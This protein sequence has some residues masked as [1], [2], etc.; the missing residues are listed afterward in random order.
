MKIIDE[1]GRLFGKIN[2]LDLIIAV[3]LIMLVI[4]VMAKFGKSEASYVTSDKVLEYT[5]K[6]EC[7]RAPT[8]DAIAQNHVGLTDFETGKNVGDIVDTKVSDSV[9]LIKLADGTYAYANH[10]DRYDLLITL[11][12][13]G[14]ET[15][16]N[17]FTTSGKKIVVGD[18]FKIYN[19]YAATTA[20]VESVKVA[21]TND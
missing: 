17:F 4:S 16:D 18:D 1:K 7:V 19:G 21:D 20:K 9:E 12:V 3:A 11:R 2:L 15:S 14:T 6:V 8:V 13:R 5:V 10:K